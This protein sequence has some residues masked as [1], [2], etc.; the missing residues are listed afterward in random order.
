MA[1]FD[2]EKNKA[3]WERHLATLEAEKEKRKVSGFKPTVTSK[4]P[5]PL[6]KK[7]GVR[8][9]TFQELVRKEEAKLRK[10]HGVVRHR[11]RE[12]A[13]QKTTGQ[14]VL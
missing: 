14:K 4:G 13:P 5:K 10:N 6:E 2:S 8:V 12:M 7:P 9:I 1:Y 11:Q 3:M